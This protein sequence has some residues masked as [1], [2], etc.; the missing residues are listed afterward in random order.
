MPCNGRPSDLLVHTRLRER[1]RAAESQQRH[2][3]SLPNFTRTV[4]GEQS[5]FKKSRPCSHM[6]RSQK[7]TPGEVLEAFPGAEGSLYQHPPTA[8]LHGAGVMA[9][10]TKFSSLLL[11]K[12]LA[13]HAHTHTH[14]TIH[15][16]L[17]L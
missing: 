17:H 9:D 1:R 2:S 13:L 15:Q 6:G 16:Y 3:G 11:G 8:H 5:S 12:S 7:L 10:Y 14:K 4:L